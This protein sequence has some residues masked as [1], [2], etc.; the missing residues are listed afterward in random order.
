MTIDPDNPVVL[1]S[2]ANEILAGTIVSALAECGIEASAT[3][4][5]T[6][7]FRAEAPGQVS[8]VVRQADLDRAKRALAE[9]EQSQGDVDWSQVDVGEP[10]ES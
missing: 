4:S 3:G 8:V 5:Y 9:I 7:G 1:T 6:S 2:V 10:E